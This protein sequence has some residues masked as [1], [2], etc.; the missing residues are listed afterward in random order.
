[1]RDKDKSEIK[2][3]VRRITSTAMISKDAILSVV[4]IS[5]S[6]TVMFSYIA[7]KSST[8][9]GSLRNSTSTRYSSREAD[10]EISVVMVDKWEVLY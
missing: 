7:S 10:V 5:V 2:M 8:F 4:V 6:V 9:I 3:I 1:M